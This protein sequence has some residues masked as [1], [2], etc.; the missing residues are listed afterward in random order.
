MLFYLILGGVVVA[1]LLW[2]KRKPLLA[3]EG[4]RVGAG[5][6][7]AAAFAAAAY[8]GVRS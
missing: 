5:V 2:G 4:W 3:G 8:A 1:W 7:S 6:A